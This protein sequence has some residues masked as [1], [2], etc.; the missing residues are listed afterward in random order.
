MK[1]LH[2]F[3]TQSNDWYYN[4]LD[5]FMF[6]F[7]VFF[8]EKTAFLISFF[9]HYSVIQFRNFW[10]NYFLNN[11][12]L[13]VGLMRLFVDDGSY[14]FII[15]SDPQQNV[16]IQFLMKYVF[17]QQFLHCFTRSSNQFLIF[18]T[19]FFS[20]SSDFFTYQL[21]FSLFW[22]LNLLSYTRCSYNLFP[23]FWWSVLAVSCAFL[24][25]V[26]AGY[27]AYKPCHVPHASR[28]RTLGTIFTEICFGVSKE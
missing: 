15:I 6:F 22:P 11:F 1:R 4:G 26:H 18:N 17:Q 8:V 10:W 27:R 24:D 12:S 28:I 25:A 13:L 21:D 2:Y 23:S 9:V 20:I 3:L 19:S 14:I 5:E 16:G 7:L